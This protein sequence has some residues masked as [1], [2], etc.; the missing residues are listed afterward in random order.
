MEEE[1]IDSAAHNHP[2]MKKH[3]IRT[4]ETLNLLW[5]K[6]NH[7]QNGC[8]A[9]LITISEYFELPMQDIWDGGWLAWPSTADKE[10][11]LPS[12]I[13]SGRDIASSMSWIC[14]NDQVPIYELEI[15][16]NHNTY[17]MLSHRHT[18]DAWAFTSSRL[19]FQLLIPRLYSF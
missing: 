2:P 4:A 9:W 7:S 15:V 14:Y 5:Q 6:V 19:K 12:Q 16:Q 3:K 18:R 11:V 8:Q 1:L 13:L 17:T 10:L